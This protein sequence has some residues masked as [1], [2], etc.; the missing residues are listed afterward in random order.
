MK[1]H[2]DLFIASTLS[3]LFLSSGCALFIREYRRSWKKRRLIEQALSI[4]SANDVNHIIHGTFSAVRIFRGRG[5]IAKF[6]GIAERDAGVPPLTTNLAQG[7]AV[8]IRRHYKSEV[9]ALRVGALISAL[10]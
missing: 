2:F 1:Q 4:A 6:S 7:S 8:Y 5:C 10:T 9:K 3:A